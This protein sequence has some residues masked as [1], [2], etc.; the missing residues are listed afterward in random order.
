MM[1][2]SVVTQE[3]KNKKHEED[4]RAGEDGVKWGHNWQQENHPAFEHT[5]T[6]NVYCFKNLLFLAGLHM[7]SV[8]IA[9]IWL[10]IIPI[11]RGRESHINL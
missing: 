9:W 11:T 10:I 8:L 3:K 4:P 6:V 1:P 5:E 7:F 2:P